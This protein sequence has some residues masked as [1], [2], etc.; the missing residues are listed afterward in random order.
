MAENVVTVAGLFKSYETAAAGGR[1][2]ERAGLH[3]VEIGL[4][5]NDADSKQAERLDRTARNPAVAGAAIGG[6][7][8]GSVTVLAAL[9]ALAIPG[10]GPVV[11]AD[12]DP[13]LIRVRVETGSIR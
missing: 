13:R 5:S 3:H 2:L 6:V 11:A 10:V 4:V 9:T 7:L 8:G 1:V 12:H